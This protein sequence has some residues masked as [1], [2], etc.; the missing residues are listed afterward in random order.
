MPQAEARAPRCPPRIPHS[1]HAP[2]GSRQSLAWAHSP[3]PCRGQR[4]S[5]YERGARPHRLLTDPEVQVFGTSALGSFDVP[6]AYY[7]TGPIR[8]RLPRPGW[9]NNTSGGHHRHVHHS[10]P[11]QPGLLRAASCTLAG[12]GLNAAVKDCKCSHTP[13]LPY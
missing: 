1:P 3:Q 13:V 10:L 6:T 9:G 2:Q 8:L 11:R 4:P 7:G 12:E 5:S